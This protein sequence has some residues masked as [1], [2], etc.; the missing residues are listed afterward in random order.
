MVASTFAAGT[1]VFNR[2]LKSVDYAVVMIYHGLFGF[3]ASLAI[4][5]VNYFI[6][7][8]ETVTI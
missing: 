6:V 1:A 4:L 3:I 7:N 2:S 8:P 5:T